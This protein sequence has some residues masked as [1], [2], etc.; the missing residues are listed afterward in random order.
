M[1]RPP[2]SGAGLVLSHW[3]QPGHMAA[4]V[5]LER[6]NTV[7][8][9]GSRLSSTTQRHLCCLQSGR[10]Q[11]PGPVQWPVQGLRRHL[12]LYLLGASQPSVHARE[13]HRKPPNPHALLTMVSTLQMQ[14]FLTRS[15]LK[16]FALAAEELIRVRTCSPHAGHLGTFGSR[17]VR[18]LSHCPLTPLPW[19]R[20]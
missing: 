11:P 17:R 16:E 2:G 7:Q 5:L 14:G 1:R 6:E 10:C 20:S 19:C 4:S 15:V 13:P 12:H 18:N 3:P 9:W 8:C